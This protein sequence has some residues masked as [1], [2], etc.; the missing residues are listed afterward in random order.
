M[1][2]DVVGKEALPTEVFGMNTLDYLQRKRVKTILC[3][4]DYGGSSGT[5][6]QTLKG[7]IYRPF[8]PAEYGFMQATPRLASYTDILSNGY[9]LCGR[10][11]RYRFTS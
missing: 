8:C 6:Q 11:R 3:G 5:D 1:L 9:A 2:T 4:R 7:L 10:Q